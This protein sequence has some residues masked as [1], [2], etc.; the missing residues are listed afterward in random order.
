MQI[1]PVRTGVTYSFS[2]VAVRSS[3]RGLSTQYKPSICRSVYIGPHKQQIPGIQQRSSQVTGSLLSTAPVYDRCCTPPGM[4]HTGQRY[5][6]I[7]K[8]NSKCMCVFP[9]ALF[10]LSSFSSSSTQHTIRRRLW[11]ATSGCSSQSRKS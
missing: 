11:K 10:Q 5:G 7:K 1:I 2:A 9:A 8:S 4:N 6:K 3:W